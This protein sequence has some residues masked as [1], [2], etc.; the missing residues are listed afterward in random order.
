[1]RGREGGAGDRVPSAC[2]GGWELAR[3]RG[4]SA[5][6]RENSAWCR[7]VVTKLLSADPRILQG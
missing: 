7:P 4:W 6:G 5:A 3:K 2:G 1:M